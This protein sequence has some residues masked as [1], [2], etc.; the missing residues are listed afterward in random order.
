MSSDKPLTEDEYL[1]RE[2]QLAQ[3]ALLRLRG[4]IQQ[5]LVRSADLGAWTERFPL[6]VIGTAAVSGL[7][8]GW[9]LGCSLRG[10]KHEA[11]VESQLAD[12]VGQATS[13]GS[14]TEQSGK[15]HPASWLIGG[16]G[17][18]AGALA[19]AAVGAASE[20][21]VDVVKDTVRDT[22][23]P[24]TSA[25]QSVNGDAEARPSKHQTK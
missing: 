12:G 19:S 10:S 20:A 13:D 7:A 17:T 25:S 3:E 5:S 21:V 18:L 8:A 23:R 2:S 4:E 11:D 24:N 6:P 16:L 22:L 14:T 15:S 1:Q 9:A